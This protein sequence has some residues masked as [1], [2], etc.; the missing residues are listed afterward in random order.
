MI[1][2]GPGSGPGPGPAQALGL[3]SPNSRARM[4]EELRRTGVADERV[5]A[6]MGRVR[7]HEFVSAGFQAQAYRIDASLPIGHGQ[8]ITQPRVV[9]AMTAALMAG[10]L[11]RRVLEIGTGCG[12]QTAVLAELVE[13]V[14]TVERV[15]PLTEAARL[16]LQGMGYRNVHTIWGD[17]SSGWPAF[18]PYDGI[19]VTAAAPTPALVTALEAQLSPGGVLVIPVAGAGAGGLDQHLEL[20]ERLPQTVLGAPPELRR[21][22]LAAVNFVPLLPGRV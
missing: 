18:G 10:G 20:V 1:P 22:T 19:L 9:A 11:R 16:R 7:R 6:A 12:Y 4:L 21:R 17:G 3:L 13:A 2:G 14:F 8:T 5:L 15:K